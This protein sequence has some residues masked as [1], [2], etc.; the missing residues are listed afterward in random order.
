M[1]GSDPEMGAAHMRVMS[2]S[3][4]HGAV[5]AREASRHGD[6]KFGE[7]HFDG[8]DITL[9]FASATEALPD[10]ERE[11]PLSWYEMELPSS[12]H[13]KYVPVKHE[14]TATISLPQYT[15]EQAPQIMSVRNRIWR[16]DGGT[17]EQQFRFIDGNIYTQ[18]AG[19]EPVG[20]IDDVFAGIT[21]YRYHEGNQGY[22]AGRWGGPQAPDT[23]WDVQQKMQNAVRNLVVI[24]GEPWQRATEPVYK[25]ES[26]G[27]GSNSYITVTGAPADDES[28]APDNYFT[29]DQYDEALAYAHAEMRGEAARGLDEAERIVVADGFTPGSTWAPAPRLTYPEPEWDM[30]GEKLHTAFN[31]FRTAIANVP[32]G[33]SEDADGRKRIDWSK[34]TDEQQR[35]YK[36]FVTKSL[37]DGVLL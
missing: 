25:V 20:S 4:S 33:I 6:G 7:Q 13:R 11:L 29:A 17:Y 3:I 9:G 12:R 14:G 30:K 19:D 18:H 28:T 36:E 26:G 15:T 22:E 31:Q 16:G 23:K 32:G 24:D 1:R 37:E 35:H 10:I 8:D 27:W 5:A 21:Q 2:I 34:Y